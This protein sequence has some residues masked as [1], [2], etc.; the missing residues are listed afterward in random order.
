MKFKTSKKNMK[1]SYN[2]IIKIGY[3]QAWYLLKFEKPLAYSANSYGWACDYYDVMGTLISTGY[4]P[5]GSKGLKE[6]VNVYDVLAHYEEK[7]RK[8]F[9][10]IRNVDE[11]RNKISCL[12]EQ[13][14]NEVTGKEN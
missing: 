2:T 9:C 12:L 4:S 5:I 1:E 6:D 8:I 7:A 3:C 11:Q 14:I 10:E 13:F